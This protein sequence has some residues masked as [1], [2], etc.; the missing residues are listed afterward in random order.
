VPSRG[1]PWCYIEV[2]E[3][4]RKLDEVRQERLRKF[5]KVPWT[6]RLLDYYIA[7][8]ERLV[9]KKLKIHPRHCGIN[10]GAGEIEKS[11][12]NAENKKNI[13]GSDEIV[14]PNSCQ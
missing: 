3:R 2:G 6:T 9:Q 12:K 7:R 1:S 5:G 4:L 10:G 14:Q 8:L 13:G 11:Q